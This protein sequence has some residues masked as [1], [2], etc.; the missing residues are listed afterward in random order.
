[1]ARPKKPVDEKTESLKKYG[2]FNPHPQKVAE[3]RFRIHD[4]IFRS[5]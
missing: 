1:M 4:R 2:A 3:K 5:P